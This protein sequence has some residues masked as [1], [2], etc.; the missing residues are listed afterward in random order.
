[1]EQI[2]FELS[3]GSALIIHQRLPA[4]KIP[5]QLHQSLMLNTC[6]IQIYLNVIFSIPPQSSEWIFPKRFRH[7]KYLL[8]STWN[9]RVSNSFLLDF[10]TVPILGVLIQYL[11]C[12]NQIFQFKFFSFWVHIFLYSICFPMVHIQ[13]HVL[14]NAE[15]YAVFSR[16]WR[17][18]GLCYIWIVRRPC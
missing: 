5:R 7:R 18:N 6:I 4:D 14:S 9:L 8:L 17:Q 2:S 15:G 3:Q 12:N 11:S 10:T 16:R 1:M 13:S